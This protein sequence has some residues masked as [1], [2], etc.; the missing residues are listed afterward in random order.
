MSHNNIIELVDNNTGYGLSRGE[1][2]NQKHFINS[3]LHHLIT[4]YAHTRTIK[5][6]QL[7][8]NNSCHAGSIYHSNVKVLDLS[9]NNISKIYPGFFRPAEISLTNLYLGYNSLMV[10]VSIVLTEF[11]LHSTTYLNPSECYARNIWKYAT[12]T[13]KFQLNGSVD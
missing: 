9:H 7:L 1:H 8:D 4:P 11:S 3:L 5:F 2:G 13:S 6:P 12:F 10:S